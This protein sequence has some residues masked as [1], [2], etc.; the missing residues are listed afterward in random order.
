MSSRT[1]AF[2]S[3]TARKPHGCDYCGQEISAGQ[4]YKRWVS[5]ADGSARSVAAHTACD[6]IARA[7]WRLTDADPDERFVQF[8]PLSEW[9]RWQEHPRQ[10]LSEMGRDWPAGEIDRLASLL[11]SAEE[12]TP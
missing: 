6:D 4:R 11:L 8:E 2:C 10:A 9:V 3:P 5:I 12:A 1:I 7:Y